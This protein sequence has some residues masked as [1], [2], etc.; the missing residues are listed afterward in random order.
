MSF[1]AYCQALQ[2]DL[3]QT[4]PALVSL[5]RA[6]HDNIL[7]ASD[8]EEWRYLRRMLDPA[9]TQ[10]NVRKVIKTHSAVLTTPV[11]LQHALCVQPNILN[12]PHRVPY[13]KS[14]QHAY[15]CQLSCGS[16]AMVESQFVSY[17]LERHQMR[18]IN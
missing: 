12:K 17:V 8:L 7:A 1:A 15:T 16:L 9:F 4:P 10:D 6:P 18:L 14:M 13:F 5:Q 2:P 3:A 11:S